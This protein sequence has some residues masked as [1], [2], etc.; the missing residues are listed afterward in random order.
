MMAANSTLRQSSV[1]YF[2]AAIMAI[3]LLPTA[4]SSPAAEDAKQ[5]ASPGA[6]ETTATH[7]VSY[8]AKA[9]LD[10]VREQR[11]ITEIEAKQFLKT[12]VQVG[13]QPSPSAARTRNDGEHTLWDGTNLVVEATAARHKQIAARLDTF[14]KFG[15]VQIAVET[16]FVSLFEDEMMQ[17]LPDSTHAP[18]ESPESDAVKKGEIQDLAYDRP[19]GSHEGTQVSRAQFIVQT[20]SPVRF[21][22]LDKQEGETWLNRCQSSKQTNILQAPKVTMFNGQTANIADVLKPRSSSD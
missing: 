5:P 2:G 13:P 22:I 18:L 17:V 21:R 9:A 19:L 3:S 14:G 6:N 4:T 7:V 20:V 12:W 16:R 11:G 15:G 10:A 8:P 1:K